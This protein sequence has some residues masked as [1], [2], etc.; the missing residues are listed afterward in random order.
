MK[1]KLSLKQ[2]W[3]AVGIFSLILPIF[4]P[5]AEGSGNFV[6]NL[7]GIVNIVM[8][9]L[10]FPCSFFGLPI[11]FFAW[12]VLEINP[13]SIE[14]AYLNTILFFV[15]GLVQ[16]FWIARF[17]YPTETP[18]QKLNLLGVNSEMQLSEAAAINNVQYSDP[19]GRSP[20]ERVFR[21]KDS[22]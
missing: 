19:E 6:L 1:F 17:W 15:L 12:Y 2:I 7:I 9:I 22:R 8:F 3:L 4:L 16:W 5:S 10:S 20:I 18:F 13:L 11:V 14:G 21:D